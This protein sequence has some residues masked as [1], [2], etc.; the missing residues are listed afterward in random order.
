MF[1]RWL[2]P[3][4]IGLFFILNVFPDEESAQIYFKKAKEQVQKKNYPAALGLFQ[5]AIDE[6]P[7]FPDAYFERGVFFWQM[8]EMAEAAKDFT[9]ASELL[10]KM[11]KRSDAQAKLSAKIITYLNEYGKISSEFDE[12]NAKYMTKF[13][14]L[15]GKY[16]Q[17]ANE[18]LL[19]L[20]ERLSAMEPDRKEITEQLNLFRMNLMNEEK[21]LMDPL[22]N[23]DNLDG[24][25]ISKKAWWKVENGAITGGNLEP[26]MIQLQHT[27]V[28]EGNYVI[29]LDVRLEETPGDQF[30]GIAFAVIDYDHTFYWY[31]IRENSICL[32]RYSSRG[33]A[34]PN[35]SRLAD[36]AL[37]DTFKAGDWNNLR[38]MIK[39]EKVSCYLNGELQ[40]EANIPE[41]K[42]TRFKGLPALSA[43]KCKASFRNILYLSE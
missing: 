17:S 2:S 5:K 26:G 39:G 32:F 36:R 37:P 4:A 34:V 35:L 1:L 7:D 9:K 42:Q 40:F 24:W 15:A 13:L 27:R 22:F 30:F 19:G 33:E 18:Y 29:S 12:M 14:D 16:P 38:F 41:G 11:E 31:A 21:N 8:K 23:G 6:A 43:E 20:M 28:L 10:E 25:D 3:L